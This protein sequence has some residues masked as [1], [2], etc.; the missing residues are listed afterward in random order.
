MTSK[1]TRYMDQPQVVVD[2]AEVVKVM[3]LPSPPYDQLPQY[4]VTLRIGQGKF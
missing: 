2:A 1:D 3:P 4:F